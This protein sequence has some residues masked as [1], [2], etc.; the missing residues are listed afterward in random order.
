MYDWH[1]CLL[2]WQLWKKLSRIKATIQTVAMTVYTIENFVVTFSS[3]Q[4]LLVV[5]SSSDYCNSQIDKLFVKMMRPKFFSSQK[6]QDICYVNRIAVGMTAHICVCTVC[7]ITMTVLELRLTTS[8]SWWKKPLERLNE[9]KKYFQLQEQS[10]LQ[11]IT[12]CWQSK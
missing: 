12:N 4:F 8:L 3:W 11:S 7:S 1:G 10:K 9:I 5:S 2:K 6:W